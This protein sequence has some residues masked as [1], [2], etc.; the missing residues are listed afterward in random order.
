[1]QKN[2]RYALLHFFESLPAPRYF[3]LLVQVD[4]FAECPPVFKHMYAFQWVN[5]AY[6]LSTVSINSETFKLENNKDFDITSMYYMAQRLMPEHISPN[7][8]FFICGKDGIIKKRKVASYMKKN[9]LHLLIP[10]M[11]SDMEYELFIP[12]SEPKYVCIPHELMTSNI[13]VISLQ[14]FTEHNFYLKYYEE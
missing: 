6:D 3:G 1:M 4:D 12:A 13:S 10:Y 14:K 2:Y 7:T 9:N 8:T 5:S 11:A